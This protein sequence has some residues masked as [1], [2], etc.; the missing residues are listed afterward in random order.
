MIRLSFRN[1]VEMFHSELCFSPYL[2]QQPHL[3]DDFL[4]LAESE[5]L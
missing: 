3:L 2:P 1:L 4:R 5:E